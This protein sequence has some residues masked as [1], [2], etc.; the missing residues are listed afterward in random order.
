MEYSRYLENG[1]YRLPQR[2]NLENKQRKLR[3]RLV[4]LEWMPAP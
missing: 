4:I 2:L 3:L 1:R